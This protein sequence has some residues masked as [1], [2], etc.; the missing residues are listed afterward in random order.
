MGLE[1]AILKRGDVWR[2]QIQ[3][4]Q[5]VNDVII[6]DVTDR[7]FEYQHVGAKFMKDRQKHGTSRIEFLELVARR[8]DRVPA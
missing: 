3:G 2:V 6:T 8:D 7:T 5:I 4:H 1:A